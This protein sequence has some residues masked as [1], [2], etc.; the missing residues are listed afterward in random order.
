M[1]FLIEYGMFAAKLVTIVVCIAIALIAVIGFVFAR[2]QMG[3]HD[4]HIEVKKLNDKYQNMG[5]AL[6]SALLP[7][8]AFKAELKQAKNVI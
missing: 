7:E 3:A 8:K 2:S 1:E 5:M 4:D 6:K